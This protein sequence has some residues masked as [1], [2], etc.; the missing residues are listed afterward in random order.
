MDKRSGPVRS[1]GESEVRYNHA[2]LDWSRVLADNTQPK[3]MTSGDWLFALGCAAMLIAAA[4]AAY[5]YH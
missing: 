4:V 3:A 1:H 2:D 5:I